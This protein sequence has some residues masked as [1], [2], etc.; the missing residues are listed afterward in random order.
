MDATWWDLGKIKRSLWENED[1]AAPWPSHSPRNPT[2]G[3]NACMP[4]RKQLSWDGH[5]FHSHFSAVSPAPLT[6]TSR[7]ENHLLQQDWVLWGWWKKEG[8]LSSEVWGKKKQTNQPTTGTYPKP[9]S[10]GNTQT[11]RK[12][13]ETQSDRSTW[14]KWSKGHPMGSSLQLFQ[15]C[16]GSFHH[17]VSGFSCLTQISKHKNGVIS[18]QARIYIQGLGKVRKWKAI[19]ANKDC[20][21]LFHSFSLSIAPGQSFPSRISWT[22]APQTASPPSHCSRACTSCS[23][24]AQ[25]TETKTSLPSPP[26][27]F[28]PHICTCQVLFLMLE[29]Y[30]CLR[31]HTCSFCH[32]LINS[33]F[34]PVPDD[35]GGEKKVPATE[36]KLGSCSCNENCGVFILSP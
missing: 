22:I 30:I 31:I 34:I 17:Q 23:S 14:E 18:L 16:Q 15:Q 13:R 21:K 32:T 26:T 24:R 33:V 11:N 36:K 25:H 27:V 9:N 10:K 7:G 4:K 1:S 20:K 12:A 29:I 35:A 19:N 8:F 2:E 3:R 28:E 5:W 6:E